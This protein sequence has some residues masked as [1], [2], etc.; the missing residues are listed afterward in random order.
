MLGNSPAKIG[1]NSAGCARVRL[2]LELSGPSIFC[3]GDYNRIFMDIQ[4]DIF[5]CRLH[6]LGS[7]FGCSGCC[8]SFSHSPAALLFTE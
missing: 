8:S 4:P 3:D 5:I 6:V 2:Q 1:I 7:V